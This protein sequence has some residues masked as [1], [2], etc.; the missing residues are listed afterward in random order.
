MIPLFGRAGAISSMV[1]VELRKKSGEFLKLIEVR[2]GVNLWVALRRFGVPVG[3]SCSGVGVCGKCAVRLVSDDE[4]SLTEK[5]E[6][7]SQ[8]IDKQGL[9]SDLRLSCLCRVNQDVIVSADYW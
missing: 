8:T 4:K 3:A 9:Q 1:K 2:R 7:E 6:F 5:S